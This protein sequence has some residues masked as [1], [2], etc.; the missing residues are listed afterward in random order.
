M[1]KEN[2]TRIFVAKGENLGAALGRGFNCDAVHH[3]NQFVLPFL[4]KGG[5][6][7]E[8]DIRAYYNL[9]RD[10]LFLRFAAAKMA[11]IEDSLER[12]L[13]RLTAEKRFEDFLDGQQIPKVEIVSEECLQFVSY[14]EEI[15]EFVID[16]DAYLSLSDIYVETPK[17]RE[18]FDNLK[19][20]I[21]ALSKLNLDGI[22]IA[23]L[24]RFEE[25]KAKLQPTISTGI[26][27]NFVEL[28]S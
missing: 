21:A 27:K 10:K 3:F 26:W 18:I 16:E 8:R 20:A 25:G 24:V 17:E 2:I 9:D 14:D 11:E 4:K 15:G 28:N 7:E 1:A 23:H 22:N 6:F 12:D 5:I 13:F 19:A